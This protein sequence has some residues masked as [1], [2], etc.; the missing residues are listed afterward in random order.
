MK[1]KLILVL[2]VFAVLVSLGASRIVKVPAKA[3]LA[4]TASNT[5]PIGGMGAEDH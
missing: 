2:I 4:S 5:S 3:E 1:T